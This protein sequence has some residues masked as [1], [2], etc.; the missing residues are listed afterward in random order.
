M[1]RHERSL[2]ILL[3]RYYNPPIPNQQPAS[4][5]PMPDFWRHSGFHLLDAGDPGPGPQAAAKPKAA[6]RAQGPKGRLHLT[7]DFLRAYFARPEVAPV[8]QS[9]TAE[10]ALFARLQQSPRAV[11]SEADLGGLA[12]ADARDNYRV[13]LR[14]REHL[15]A[16]DSIESAYAA[17]F[18]APDGGARDFSANG[19]PPLFADQLAHVIVRHLLEGCDDPLQLRAAELF[20]R[21]QRVHASEG[22]LLLA[23]LE[24]VDMQAARAREGSQF[25][26]LGRLIIEAQ[27]PLAAVELDVLDT[28]NAALY[29]TRDERHDMAIDLG[30][31]RAALDAL[32]RV[33]EKWLTYFFDLPMRVRPLRRIETARMDWFIGL[34]REA[35]AM[36]NRL[37][38]GD[39]LA[40]DDQRRL[41]ALLELRIETQGVMGSGR[42]SDAAPGMPLP[43]I[44]DAPVILALAM[45]P[46]NEVR[47]KP[48]NLLINFPIR[49]AA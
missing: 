41:I 30:Y 39:P 14:L 25:G 17:L 15:L 11:V 3:L 46:Q 6:G 35:T 10:R 45:N 31:G 12:D 5:H 2:W 34:D 8:A 40:P 23:D 21:E 22:H 7:D 36:L 43:H 37:Y 26:S 32:C 33:I 16:H 48:Q 4:T 29:W 44:A 28:G 1:R 27:T 20:F 18:V 49:R 24:T 47:M 13:V 42:A 19:I 9:C 38:N